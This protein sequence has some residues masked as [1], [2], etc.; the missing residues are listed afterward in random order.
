MFICPDKKAVGT[1]RP[2]PLRR[3]VSHR[4]FSW[5]LIFETT[6]MLEVKIS[7]SYILWSYLWLLNLWMLNF[8]TYDLQLTTSHHFANAFLG[9][10]FWGEMA[11]TRQQAAA[12]WNSGPSWLFGM[13]SAHVKL[14][15]IV[16]GF[17]FAIETLILTCFIWDDLRVSS[18]FFLPF[19]FGMCNL[20]LKQQQED[21]IHSANKTGIHPGRMLIQ[22]MK[23]CQVQAEW[24]YANDLSIDS[25]S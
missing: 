7:L 21:C 9:R 24:V 6:F 10:P 5:T 12:V 8:L 16:Q 22:Q 17:F 3:G 2:I 11:S 4:F 1:R 13:P 19:F 14:S 18:I 15:Y 25:Y 20:P 23:I